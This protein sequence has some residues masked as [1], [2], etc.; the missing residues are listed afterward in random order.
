MWGNILTHIG[1]HHT[2]QKW[3]ISEWIAIYTC[4]PKLSGREPNE[5]NSTGPLHVHHIWPTI[6]FTKLSLAG[7]PFMLE[8]V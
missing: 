7:W 8:K 5:G 3:A 2:I 6:I 1:V 4:P